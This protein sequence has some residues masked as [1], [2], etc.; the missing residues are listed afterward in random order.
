MI[1]SAGLRKVFLTAH[2][3]AS[4]GWVGA[5]IAFL[6]LAII[7]LTSPDAQTVRGSYLIMDRAGWLVLLPLAIA[8]L[9]TGLIQGLG[10][11]WGLFRHYWV[12][13]KLII[14][15]IS[16]GVLITYMGTFAAMA[17]AAADLGVP[18]VAV[19][20]SSP[21]LHSILAL[22]VLMI[23]TVLSIYKPKAM[24]RYGQRN[25]NAQRKNAK[26]ALAKT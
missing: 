26:P 5:V 22:I 1:M 24:T 6:G 16:T 11:K 13:F 12:I 7:G 25:Q 17:A 14:N 10:T 15:L 9:L 20:N 2:V 8:S 21:R 4:V 19:R 3:T 23:A 18:L